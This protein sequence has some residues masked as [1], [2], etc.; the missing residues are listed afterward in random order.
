MKQQHLNVLSFLKT[1]NTG[2]GVRCLN[3]DYKYDNICL[4]RI[5]LLD[6]MPS[7]SAGRAIEAEECKVII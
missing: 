2:G 6:N 1:M 5:S 3:L 7:D 4:F